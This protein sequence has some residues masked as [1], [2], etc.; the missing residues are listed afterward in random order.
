MH[1]RRVGH[2]PNAGNDALCFVLES[3]HTAGL[4][5]VRPYCMQFVMGP[6]IRGLEIAAGSTTR[7]VHWRHLVS[8]YGRFECH[9][10]QLTP[11]LSGLV[12]AAVCSV[13]RLKDRSSCR[14]PISTATD[15]GADGGS[16]I[17]LLIGKRGVEE[18][19]SGFAGNN[20]VKR[21]WRRLWDTRFT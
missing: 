9:N 14:L 5:G 15:H 19:E 18:I 8:R 13:K 11:L 16:S 2:H 10:L 21:A 4:L 3:R 7:C 17:L 1:A 6:I 20:G 12:A